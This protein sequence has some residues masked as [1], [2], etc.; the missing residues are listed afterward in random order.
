M[1]KFT[2]LSGALAMA[3]VAFAADYVTPTVSTA[4][5]PKYYKI[6]SNR[7]QTLDYSGFPRLYKAGEEYPTAGTNNVEFTTWETATQDTTVYNPCNRVVDFGQGSLASRGYFGLLSNDNVAVSLDAD[8]VPDYT[9]YWYFTPATPIEDTDDTEEGVSVD[10]VGCYINNMTV[11]KPMGVTSP[12]GVKNPGIPFYMVK[13]DNY[14][15]PDGAYTE[16]F[17]D[18]SFTFSTKNPIT[19]TSCLDLNNYFGIGGQDYDDAPYVSMKICWNPYRDFASADAAA[20]CNINNGGVFYFEEA[21]AADVAAALEAYKANGVAPRI[22]AAKETAIASVNSITNVPA[23]WQDADI[24]AAQAAV[25]AIDVDM[26]TLN[27]VAE[28]DAA[29]DGVQEQ[30][31]AILAQVV[32]KADGKK[33]YFHCVQ[34]RQSEETT[35]YLAA[36]QEEGDIDEATGDAIMVNT[37]VAL[38]QEEKNETCVWTLEYVSG[39]NF[40][41]YNEATGTYAASGADL[42]VNSTWG[43]TEDKEEAGLFQIQGGATYPETMTET[44]TEVDENTGEMIE[45]PGDYVYANHGEA[46]LNNVGIYNSDSSSY[47]YLHEAGS[48]TGYNIV[49]WLRDSYDNASNWMISFD[50]NDNASINSVVAEN[51]EK[52][53]NAIYDLSGRRVANL[54][55][56]GLYIVNG[57]KILI[58]K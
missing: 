39:L 35:E 12:F 41:L 55:R 33:V 37:L 6:T 22:A 47:G 32:K 14:E 44:T 7:I 57:K 15:D 10:G 26:T 31:D 48:S 28:I 8:Q 52:A 5:A 1:K 40:R 56:N 27:T 2:L 38:P 17:N 53:A 19:N 4:D 24:A 20:N 36:G 21:D 51:T 46:W 29:I 16:T 54:S 18:N 45:I 11:S 43:M 50:G 13:L 49:T 3:A 23:L 42:A 34:N 58:N 9:L 30:A 25:A